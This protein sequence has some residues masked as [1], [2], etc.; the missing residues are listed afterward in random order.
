[1]FTVFVGPLILLG[2]GGADRV[3]LL[4][5]HALQL[6][7]ASG[8]QGPTGLLLFLS[9]GVLYLRERESR[10][11]LEQERNVAAQDAEREALQK[12]ALALS[13]RLT[14]ENARL[15]QWVHRKEARGESVPEAVRTAAEAL[16]AAIAELNE[17][18]FVRPYAVTRAD[19]QKKAEAH[20]AH[21]RGIPGLQ[22]CPL[23]E[24][25]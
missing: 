22:H 14:A 2:A 8:L 5:A 10:R 4:C 1:M 18:A 19:A 21:A 6:M 24:R 23:G 7:F 3:V 11:N 17:E 9:L 12:T 20:S 16:G 15:L 13:S 25:C